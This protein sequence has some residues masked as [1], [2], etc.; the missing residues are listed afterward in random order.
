MSTRCTAYRRR[1]TTWVYSC[2]DTYIMDLLPDFTGCIDLRRVESIIGR[3]R[4]GICGSREEAC[5]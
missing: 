4:D 2:Q 3:R 5:K 1:G